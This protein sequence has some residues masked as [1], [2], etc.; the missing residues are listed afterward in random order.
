MRVR[1][2]ARRVFVAAVM[3][4]CLGASGCGSDSEATEGQGIPESGTLP[5]TTTTEA[6]EDT[7]ST[8]EPSGGTETTTTVAA[9]EEALVEIDVAEDEVDV[10]WSVGGGSADDSSVVA[11]DEGT[12]VTLTVT[13]DRADVVRVHGIG[14]TTP[15]Q[16]GVP[17]TV[18]FVARLPGLFLVELQQS[19]LPLAQLQVE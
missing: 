8:T 13:A 9:G 18:E 3:I 17:G 1:M 6:P 19:H 7:T 2:T 10:S 4:L 15:L 5:E 12:P 14:L 16:P 11:I